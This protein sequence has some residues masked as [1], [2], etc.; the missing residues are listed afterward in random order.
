MQAIAGG[1]GL[2]GVDGRKVDAVDLGIIAALRDDPRQTNKAISA[3][4]KVSETTIAQRL[5]ALSDDNVMRVV[6]QRE[7]LGEDFSLMCL[8]DIDTFGDSG[9]VAGQI[10]ELPQVISVSRCFGSSQLL[11]NVRAKDRLDLDD[12]LSHRIGTI[13]GIMRMRPNLCLR[14]IKYVSDFGDLSA[15]LPG[16]AYPDSDDREAQILRILMD[17]ARVSNREIARQLSVSE[18]SVRQRI[19]RMTE[20][21]ALQL[22]VVCN[23]L[24]LNIGAIA[25]VRIATTPADRESVYRSLEPHA[26]VPFVGAM[27]GDYD[28]WAIVQLETPEL[29][30]D[31]C[32]QNFAGLPVV[33]T[34]RMTTLV[35]T[36]LHR[37]DL[38]QIG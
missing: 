14:V 36:Y 38:A 5:R 21:K 13:G 27:A 9:I 33:L 22:S 17:D 10:A 6:A 37:Y 29:V 18:G 32:E 26:C 34:Y 3:S 8:I 20:D 15:R 16:L 11:V 4:L 19:K 25:V 30:A 35:R 1:D 2:T 23:P 7:V 28:T 24:M 12:M 31:F